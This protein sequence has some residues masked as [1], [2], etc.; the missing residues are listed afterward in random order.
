MNDTVLK[1]GDV[2]MTMHVICEAVD[3]TETPVY[4]DSFTAVTG[5]ERKKCIGVRVDLSADFSIL[6]S[7]I[8]ISLKNACKSETVKVQYKCPEKTE[9]VFDRPTFRCTPVFQD[10]QIDYYD[11]SL[12]MT[13]PLKGNGL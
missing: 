7:S 3:I 2:D 8:A 1:I 5:A 9:T 10:G 11:V 6:D 13:C 12:S 4:S